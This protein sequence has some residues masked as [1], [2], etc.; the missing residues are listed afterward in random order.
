MAECFIK[1]ESQC[2]TDDDILLYYMLS[3]TNIDG[4]CYITKEKTR[5]SQCLKWKYVYYQ[6]LRGLK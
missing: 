2:E 6:Y 1:I 4:Q 5:K 3:A